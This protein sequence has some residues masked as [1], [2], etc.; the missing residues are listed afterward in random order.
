MGKKFEWR[1]SP[2]GEFDQYCKLIEQFEVSPRKLRYGQNKD[3]SYHDLTMI[4]VETET[5]KGAFTSYINLYE[6]CVSVCALS[7]GYFENDDGELI[8]TGIFFNRYVS[9]NKN[10]C[11]LGETVF[12]VRTKNNI[13]KRAIVGIRDIKVSFDEEAKVYKI[14]L[15][16]YSSKG[17]DLIKLEIPYLD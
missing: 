12:I 11:T 16:I 9:S 14:D 1:E 5:S 13:F 17:Y 2:A 6:G 4:P 15:G 10:N 8:E 3:R 7:C